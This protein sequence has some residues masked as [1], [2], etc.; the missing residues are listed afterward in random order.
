MTTDPITVPFDDEDSPSAHCR[1]GGRLEF[2]VGREFGQLL[3]RCPDCHSRGEWR[4]VVP[5]VQP[6]LA[7]APGGDEDPEFTTVVVGGAAFRRKRAEDND[8]PAIAARIHDLVPFTPDA[9]VS[10]RLISDAVQ[11]PIEVSCHILARFVDVGSMR[12]EKRGI[13]WHYWRVK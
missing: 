9:A 13:Y 2:K 8:T 4:R 12:R 3:E 6:E 7:P 11:V 10:A 1:C 5:H